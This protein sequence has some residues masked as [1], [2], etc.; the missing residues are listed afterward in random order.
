MNTKHVNYLPKP[1]QVRLKPELH[2]WV[3]S[4][5]AGQERSANWVINKVLEEAR[6]KTLQPEG[7]PA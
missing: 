1:V 7:V 6:A 2:E 3:H 4:Q 5:A